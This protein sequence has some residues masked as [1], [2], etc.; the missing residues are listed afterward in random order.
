MDKE[1]TNQGQKQTIRV[2]IKGV[3]PLLQNNDFEDDRGA[4]SRKGQIYDDLNEARRRLIL[5]EGGNLCQHAR[6]L[7]A[8]MR[9]AAKEFKLRGM[10]TYKAL[11]QSVVEVQPSLI[12]H[13]IAK[14]EIDKQWVVIKGKGRV[15]RCRPILPEWKLEFV[16]ENTRPEFVTADTIKDVLGAAGEYGI[17]DGRPKY[18]RFQILEFEVQHDKPSKISLRN[19]TREAVSRGARAAGVGGRG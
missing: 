6:H 11:F 10:K 17:G 15:T 3:R 16:I 4:G 7:E 1:E 9:D 5:D 18:G 19:Q 13:R 12:P 8:A 14:W 2:L